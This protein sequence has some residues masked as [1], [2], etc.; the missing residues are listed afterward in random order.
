MCTHAAMKIAGPMKAQ[1]DALVPV[2]D[3]QQMPSPVSPY[4]PGSAAAVTSTMNVGRPYA[5]TQ[6]LQ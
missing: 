4:S 3:S 2:V 1:T 5:N 6:Y